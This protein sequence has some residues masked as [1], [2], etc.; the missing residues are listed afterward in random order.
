MRTLSLA[1][2]LVAAAAS[3]QDKKAP[4]RVTYT[5]PVTGFSLVG[6]DHELR[7]QGAGKDLIADSVY[8]L[9]RAKVAPADGAARKV[10]AVEGTLSTKKVAVGFA[11]MREIT[12]D[13]L[14]LDAKAVTIVTKDNADKFPPKNKAW[15]VG[16]L[17]TGKFDLGKEGFAEHAIANGASPI[18]LVGKVT[19]PGKEE[20][21]IKAEGTL[22]LN[23]G[24]G[25]QLVLD[26]LEV[27]KGD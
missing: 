10:V 24:G 14:A 5:A 23:P 11:G 26:R 3:A 13:A 19:V 21:I 1:C 2:C 27:V 18:R 16:R 6:E 9:A 4:A 20:A 15:V 8:V 12:A 17:L 22:R 7:L 25:L